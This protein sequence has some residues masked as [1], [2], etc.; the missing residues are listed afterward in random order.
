MQLFHQCGDI[1]SDNLASVPYCDRTVN[2]VKA[3]LSIQNILTFIILLLIQ[4]KGS[5]QHQKTSRNAQTDR[6][7]NT[8]INNVNS[9]QIEE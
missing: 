1:D 2:T 8:C 7:K 3:I 9:V 4:H 5:W 6:Q